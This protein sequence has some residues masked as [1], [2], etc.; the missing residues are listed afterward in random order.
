MKTGN[1]CPSSL[2]FAATDEPQW[3]PVMK[4][5]NTHHPPRRM[6]Q[7]G[8]PQLSPVMKTGNTWARLSAGLSRPRSL[9]GARS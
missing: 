2:P 7:Q 1:T 9:N 6:P 4:T 8:G 5:G 3:S